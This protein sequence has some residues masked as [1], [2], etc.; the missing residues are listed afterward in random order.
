MYRRNKMKGIESNPETFESLIN[1]MRVKLYKTAMAILKNDD[2]AC[3]AIQE[4]LMSAY[5]NFNSLN[6]KSYF[7]TWITRILINKCYDIIKQNKKVSSINQMMEKD[8]NESYYDVYKEESLVENVLS[9]IDPDLKVVTVL[10]Y[11]DEFSVSEIAEM[12]NIPE[13]TV[14]SRLS[15]SR[16][17]IYDILKREEGESIG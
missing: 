1:S 11:Y 14:K 8:E 10:Y 15:R 6:N 17:R 13:G 12:L 3:D 4:T 2:D 9:K 7:G 16:D 5:K